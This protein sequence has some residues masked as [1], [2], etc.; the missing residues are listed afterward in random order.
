MQDFKYVK[1]FGCGI[2]WNVAVIVE[3]LGAIAC[4][5][6]KKSMATD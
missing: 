5:H 4:S 3:E 6:A 1:Q 2:V